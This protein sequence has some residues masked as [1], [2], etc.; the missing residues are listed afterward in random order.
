MLTDLTTK[1]YRLVPAAGLCRNSPRTV[2]LVMYVAPGR[3]PSL[4]LLNDGPI[5]TVPWGP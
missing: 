2:L 4:T 5:R 1:K 3:R